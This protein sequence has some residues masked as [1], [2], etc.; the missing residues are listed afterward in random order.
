[1]A[2]FELWDVTVQ[3]YDYLND[4]HIYWLTYVEGTPDDNQWGVKGIYQDGATE[5]SEL[6]EL[7]VLNPEEE[8]IIQAKL[9]PKVH[10]SA[11]NLAVISTPNG[12]ETWNYF[13]FRPLYLH[14]NPTPPVGDTS[15]QA[16]LPL[17]YT[18][19]TATALYNYDTDNDA[20]PGRMIKKDIGG[21]TQSDLDKYQNWRILFSATIFDTL[22][23]DA[24]KGKVPDIIHVS[25]DIYAV[26]YQAN[27]DR[28]TLKTVEISSAGAITDTVVDSLEFDAVT[29]KEPE[30]INIIGDIYAIAYQAN[31]DRGTLKTVEISSAGAITDTVVDTLEFDAVIGKVPDIIHVSGN[32]Y[33]VAYQGDG[34]DG[35]LKTVNILS[36]GTFGTGTEINGDVDFIL[37][38]AIKD[39]GQSKR[40]V[41]TAYL[42]DFDG[43]DYTEIASAT[44]DTPD[45][46]GG[47][48]SWV[49]TPF[50]FPNVSY[51]LSAGHYLELKVVVGD[52]SDDDMW[53]AYDTTGYNSYMELP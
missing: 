41:V 35:F 28:G 19:P 51:T 50:N 46:Q 6:M 15:A 31:G 8:I 29:G 34:D 20:D 24:V 5:T 37:W 33:A 47:N 13:R 10:I 45:W 9:S 39:F 2:D 30:I 25:G 42:R 48:E 7:G 14:N 22:V 49:E 40:G 18:V 1:L 36:D 43:T 16:D 17:S 11:Y 53:F 27:G 3:Y 38:S 12:V 52:N 32:I 44:L 23:F 4:Y 21:V 26:A